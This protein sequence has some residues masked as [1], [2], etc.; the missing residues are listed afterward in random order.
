MKNPY[1]DI[2]T[3][4]EGGSL[5]P[6]MIAPPEVIT[7]ETYRPEIQPI[8]RE[9]GPSE[10]EERKTQQQQI[11]EE[12]ETGREQPFVP[13]QQ[14]I[15]PPTP[16]MGRVEAA[17]RQLGRDILGVGEFIESPA[18]IQWAALGGPVPKATAAI[19]S[20]EILGSVIRDF[21]EVRN[22]WDTMTP[23]QQAAA[24]TSLLDRFGFGALLGRSALRRMPA[25]QK[26]RLV[27]TQLAETA[28]ADPGAFVSALKNEMARATSPERAAI[29][30]QLA[31]RMRATLNIPKWVRAAGTTAIEGTPIEGIPGGAPVVAPP[32]GLFQVRPHLE[33]AAARPAEAAAAVA[34]ARTVPEATAAEA[35]ARG[36]EI[37]PRGTEA[38]LEAGKRPAEV[39]ETVTR[40]RTADAVEKGQIEESRQRE[41]PGTETQRIPAE[42]GG[43]DSTQPV[44][45]GEAP[46][47]A[48]GDILLRVDEP[49]TPAEIPK[50]VTRVAEPGAKPI[51]AIQEEIPDYLR[52]RVTVL[53]S[54]MDS[55]LEAQRSWALAGKDPT[56][57]A[58]MFWDGKV[59]LM[60][61]RIQ[62]GRVSVKDLIVHEVFIHQ[63]LREAFGEQRVKKIAED[64]WSSLDSQEIQTISERWQLKADQTAIIGEEWLAL[65]AERV[66]REG[67]SNSLW[68]KIVGYLKAMFRE[69]GFFTGEK[70]SDYEIARLVAAGEKAVRRARPEPTTR[71]QEMRPRG[72][73][74][75]ANIEPMARIL[76]ETR[77]RIGIWWRA[78]GPQKL[79]TWQHDAAKNLADQYADLIGNTVGNMVRRAA[80]GTLAPTA[81]E[82]LVG[83]RAAAIGE[84]V[85]MPWR[86]PDALPRAALTVAVE[87]FSDM[88]AGHP[89]AGLHGRD[90]LMAQ[91][92]RLDAHTPQ[93]KDI[94]L[95]KDR[96]SAAL[97]YGI[98]HWN[99]LE[100][101]AR[102]YQREMTM[103]AQAEQAAGID[104]LIRNGYVLHETDL[105]GLSKFDFLEGGGGS[106]GVPFLHTRIYPT[107]VDKIIGGSVPVSLDAVGLMKRRI[108]M[109]QRRINSKAWS[110]SLRTIADPT[111]GAPIATEP[112]YTQRPDGRMEIKAPTRD[113]EILQRG[114]ENYAI[115]K[116]YV[117][118][119]KDLTDPSLAR[120]YMAAQKALEA[121][122]VAKHGVLLF[123]TFHM[124]RLGLWAS[125]MQQRPVKWRKGISLLRYSTSEIAEMVRQGELPAEY[126]ADLMENKRLL[127]L[128]LRTGYNVTRVTDNLWSDWVQNTPIAGAFN[129]WLFGEF[130]QGA[131]ALAWLKEFQ[132]QRNAFNTLPERE[133]AR[134]VSRELNIR[135]GNLQNQGVFRGRTLQDISRMLFLAPQWNEGL[136]RSELGA[137]AGLPNA[138]WT[139]AMRG[140][141]ATS[142]LTQSVGMLFLSQL[143]ANQVLNYWSR[144][145]STFENPE[146]GLDSKISGYIPDY[147][148]EGPGMMLSPMGLPI[149]TIHL[150]WKG[151][152]RTGDFDDA[153][154]HYLRSRL[155]V[156]TRPLDV[157]W[158]QRNMFERAVRKEDLWNEILKSGAPI[159][160]SGGAA[161]YAARQAITGEKSEQFPGQFQRQVLSSFG[162][163][164]DPAMTATGMMGKLVADFNK[165]RGIRAS[166]EFYDSTYAELDRFLRIGNKL[167]AAKALKELQKIHTDET[168]E[169]RYERLPERNFTHGSDEREDEFIL[170][171]NPKQR[172]I[173]QH[174][175]REKIQLS[176]RYNLLR[177]HLNDLGK[178]QF[179]P[180][181]RL[182]A[183]IPLNLGREPVGP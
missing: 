10:E 174:A 152:E 1:L 65:E 75:F 12:A 130:Q 80:R 18:G 20:G 24:A 172:A 134:K 151:L 170:S 60:G 146:E 31:G 89:E 83:P 104:T 54:W 70:L 44:A 98:S 132:R 45:P 119:F 124:V 19:F 48:E 126:M 103:Q 109:G 51:S 125:I 14:L 34:A 78:R 61:D 23:G 27:A 155:H 17:A 144:G 69:A 140:K 42:A 129:R 100:P 156:S 127:N 135:F 73:E 138:L 164:T 173:Y 77:E 67:K 7:P 147:V 180:G 3:Q 115:H 26:S 101:I 55:P 84:R 88:P 159:P 111:S 108:Q 5:A 56:T 149:E 16:E 11:L 58:G 183:A 53:D 137:I 35:M 59:Y 41:H 110:Q 71:V 6:M 139:S 145:H 131:M 85:F 76:D 50:P 28:R 179:P 82:R 9:P 29:G 178:L 118:M 122:A 116:G 79:L 102:R 95:W 37:V 106:E 99:R 36:T 163:R 39:A 154:R 143:A 123:D 165:A 92:A 21:P 167:D 62:E 128:A 90:R 97:D 112:V 117:R 2:L 8:F 13:L 171:L 148:G 160:I 32:A 46:R 30:P 107:Y 120:E 38:I 94:A 157:W 86:K 49:G 43:G 66:V 15:A 175:I 133:L 142:A 105:E 52:D 81:A 25:G 87:S 22:Q 57:I 182:P 91:K 40:E 113:Y 158:T 136:I 47:P 68:A 4:A 141:V 64:I 166:G 121:M 153:L 63:G 177:A 74:G 93:D 162:V 96:M 176:L 181:L 72:E 161:F 114:H 150:L 169:K 168:I 33:A